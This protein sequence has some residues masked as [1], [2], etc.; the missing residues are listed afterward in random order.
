M[1]KIYY[2]CLAFLMLSS[3]S[4]G[5]RTLTLEECIN[6]ALDNN[7]S[8]K[9]ARNN[10]LIA[11]STFTQSKFNFLP[12]LNAGASHN[13]AE[14][15]SFDQ[16]SGG[17]VNTTTLSGGGSISAN[18][19]I[20][21]GFSNRLGMQR[22]NLLYQAAEQD[23]K[24]NVQ[25]TEASIVFSFLQVIT[26]G[27]NL[28]IA[29]QTKELLQEQLEQQEIRERAGVGNMEQVYNF[30]SQIASQDLAIVN[31]RNSLQSNRL[32]LLQLLFLDPTEEYTFEGIT[33]DDVTLEQEIE[34]YGTV[35]SRSMEFSPAVKSAELNLQASKKT[36]KIAQFA[37]L[38]S[39]SASAATGTSWSSNLRNQDGSV[40]DL[41]DQFDTN[42]RK[43][44]SLNLGIPLF[45]RFQNRTQMQQ[46][47][48]Q[49][50]NSEL[51]LEQAKN[52]LTNQVQQA[53][54][55]LV[56]AQSTYSAA[57]TSLLNLDNAYEFAKNR[58]ESGTIDFVTY[59]QSLNGKNRGE[60]ELIRA[61]YSILLRKAILDIYTGELDPANSN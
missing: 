24:G 58:Y 38:P 4:F 56:N 29:E 47:K 8:I 18:L 60:L 10:A 42:R 16:T 44:A 36:L 12:S 57:K 51:N 1:K 9:R 6:I 2:T 41:S 13:W 21:N 15:L 52:T 54:L 48:I 55:D 39:L 37:W 22:S 43:N 40:V 20:F 61:K 19:N 17:L 30:R 14:G 5:Q 32:T 45:T 46:S 31:L 33:G 27:E 53:Y 26:T 11:K 3:V 23:V 59:L 28:K 49:Y 34:E 7:I 25:A 50:L 35:F